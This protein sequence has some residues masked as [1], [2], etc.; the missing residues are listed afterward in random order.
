MDTRDIHEQSLVPFMSKNGRAF[1]KL[2]FLILLSGCIVVKEKVPDEEFTTEFTLLKKPSIA[3]SD[4][5]VRSE[6]GDMI[7]FLPSGWFFIDTENKAPSNVFAVAVNQ[8]YTLSLVFSKLTNKMDVQTIYKTDGLLGIAMQSLQIKQI[9]SLNNIRLIG[10]FEPIKNGTQK[11]YVYKFENITNKL[12][13][14][15]AIFITPLNEVYEFSLIQ[16]DIKEKPTISEE[17]FD[18]FFYAVLSTIRF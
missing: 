7:A 10:N 15:S 17:E 13:G 12:L 11:F 8:E 5:F 4:E 16:L 9:K 14:K 3:M 1:R 18:N 2:L 6:R